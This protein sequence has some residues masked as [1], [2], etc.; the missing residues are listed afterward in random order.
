MRLRR[1]LPKSLFWRSV[2]IVVAPMV[3]LQAVVAYLIVE[4]HFD[5]VTR[6]MT[7][8][9][10]SELRYLVDQVDA[11]ATPEIAR[12]ELTQA[13]QTLGYDIVLLEGA[14]L[15]PNAN[16][17]FF[18]VIGRAVEDTFREELGR[19]MFVAQERESKRVDVR[20]RTKWGV[21]AASLPRNRLFA[22]NPHLLLTWMAGAAAALIT[23]ALVYMRNQVKPIQALAE[24]ADAFGKG[25]SEPLRVSGAD[26]VRLAASAFL[27]M[28]ERIERQ[29]EQ[30]TRMLSGVSHDMRTP[31]TRMKLAVEMLDDDPEIAEFRHDLNELEHILDEFLAYA[32]GDHGEAFETADVSQLAEEVVGEARRMGVDVSLFQKVD[33]PGETEMR[34]RPRSIKR[35]LHNLID[36]A[37]AYGE[38]AMLSLTVSQRFVEFCVE[39]DGP[40]IPEDRRDDA[41]RPFNRL[42]E[43]RNRNHRGGVGLGLALALDAVRAHGGD[44]TLGVSDR[45][46][47]LKATARLPR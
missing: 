25:R 2:F 27:D 1:Y 7:G 14:S 9:A 21:V 31:L 36:N 28:R 4:R 44:L 42:D 29:M 47:G 32:R 22:S 5:G 11:A 18:D 35:C 19:A 45:L 16:P 10:A 30:R 38:R 43:A 8:G 24:A 34:I 46:G 20:V 3:I 39:D 26:E 15:P 6:Q 37:F 33:L 12:A 13:S 23:V 17:L 41:F 40:G